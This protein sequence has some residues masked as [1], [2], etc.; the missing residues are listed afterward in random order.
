MTTLEKKISQGLRV[1]EL[2]F[3]KNLSYVLTPSSKVEAYTKEDHDIFFNGEP[4]FAFL[5]HNEPTS[6]LPTV[7][8]LTKE[9]IKRIEFGD[10]ENTKVFILFH[11]KLHSVPIFKH[12]AAKCSIKI[13]RKEDI[14]EVI[15]NNR[16]VCFG[17]CPEGDN[18]FFDFDSPI[19]PFRQFG[20]IK[21]A[22]E[23]GVKMCVY[24]EHE[25]TRQA[26]SVK[27]PLIGLFRKGAKALRIPLIRP[28]RL[29][30]TYSHL[31]PT[32]TPAEFAALDAHCQRIAVA[33][34][35]DIIRKRMQE[36]YEYL[37]NVSNGEARMPRW[38]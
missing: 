27:V 15:K 31:M 2:T 4:T 14:A 25:E 17:T 16:N 22:I 30:I 35:A 21:M 32:M 9:V 38:R 10:S 8:L 37:K 36:Q 28:T 5:A 34:Q 26:V 12:L 13:T 1:T 19:A 6:W 24:S 11:P 7:A 33:D 23:L 29:L 3:L 20:L 18:C